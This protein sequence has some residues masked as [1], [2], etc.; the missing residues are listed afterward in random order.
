MQAGA[1]LHRGPGGGAAADS[2]STPDSSVVLVLAL[3]IPT[4]TPRIEKFL[5]DQR[6]ATP[7]LVMDLEMVRENY[8]ALARSLPQ[9]RIFYAMKANPAPEI[10]GMLAEIG[11]SFDTASIYEIREALAAGAPPS[12]ISFGN[13]IKKQTDIAAA[14]ALGVRLFAF[15]SQGELDK[16]AVA[17]PGAKVYCRIRFEKS[18]TADWPL[19]GK[20]G[21][22]RGA[23]C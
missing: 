2:G 23:S 22:G 14:Y 12:R 17:A 13:T 15:D 20:Y 21:H 8:L 10:M 11:S 7:C 6:P 19:G 4:M 16:L 5:A 1:R 18:K 3:G 9:A